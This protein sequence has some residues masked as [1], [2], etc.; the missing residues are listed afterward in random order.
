MEHALYGAST[1]NPALGWSLRGRP[2]SAS[3]RRDLGRFGHREW[4]PP[5]C[6]ARPTT[7]HRALRARVGS[8]PIGAPR[9]AALASSPPGRGSPFAGRVTFD[10]A[11]TAVLSQQGRPVDVTLIRDG[12]VESAFTALLLGGHELSPEACLEDDVVL[13]F[14]EFESTAAV[15]LYRAPFTA[16]SVR[17]ISMS[18][19]ELQIELGSRTVVLSWD[20]AQ[21]VAV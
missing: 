3:I 14:G 1:P 9:N 13:D 2:G 6:H 8:R 11:I 10:D 15:V 18:A 19:R 7:L 20:E 12:V 17:R 16:A 5:Q 21:P 4:A